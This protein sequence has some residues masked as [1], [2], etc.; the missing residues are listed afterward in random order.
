MAISARALRFGK[1]AIEL[2]LL[3]GDVEKKLNRLQKRFRDFGTS[4]RSIGTEGLKIS[5][6]IGGLLAFPVSLAVNLE[7]DR[8]EFT[9]LTGDA[10]T[11]NKIISELEAFALVTPLQTADLHQATRLLLNF[12]V[13]V[14]DIVPTLKR[15]GEIAG[16]DGVRLE[17]LARA[18]GQV[19]A[20]GRLM[21]QEAN[22]MSEQGFGVLAEISRTTGESI[23]DLMARMEAG[24]IT[25]EEVARAFETATSAGGRF[26]GLLDTISK[27]TIGKFNELRESITLSIRPIGQELLPRISSFLE[28]V[29][30][31]VPSLGRWV[32]R[33]KGIVAGVGE[34]AVGLGLV[35][36]AA[37]A[38]GIA[39][40]VLT[41]HPILAGITAL[42]A[43]V[44]V[45]VEALG[46]VEEMANRA[47]RALLKLSG[48]VDQ[49]TLDAFDKLHAAL[50]NPLGRFGITNPN[51][52]AVASGA[53]ASVL[54]PAIA[55]AIRPDLRPT[56]RGAG[57][58][59][60]W[61]REQE[62]FAQEAQS[63]ED[64]TA[65]A[66]LNAMKDGME[67]ELA[68]LNLEHNIRMRELRE[69]GLLT[70]EMKERADAL[71][72]AQVE[73]LKAADQGKVTEQM[74][75]QEALFSTRFAPQI[76]GGGTM[77]EDIRAIR[78]NTE[79]TARQKHGIPVV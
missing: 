12:G 35:S 24:G 63:L 6:A 21:G 56:T 64:E 9:A 67:K 48:S 57:P 58:D 73:G 4:L 55:A 77:Q 61:L 7:K 38:A 44:L 16:G 40:T 52:G 60:S 17:G 43:V 28:A 31:L 8:A 34:L 1:A 39:I 65:R 47:F 75:R 49:K 41:A 10:E 76:F 22:Q 5:G 46:G 66:R 18:F 54:P 3:S 30:S 51:P 20:K 53:S 27:T 2:S 13:A 23:K 26:S 36:T 68:L 59:D 11:A 33:N 15:L 37:L 74:R 14:Q 29:R 70:A 45:L 25:V 69:Q 32:E 50:L 78:R 72:E 42:S 79:K 62:D 19:T 71:L